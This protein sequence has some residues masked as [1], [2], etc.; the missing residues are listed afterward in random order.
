MTTKDIF[1]M[2]FIFLVIVLSFFFSWLDKNKKR[3]FVL[4]S[5]PILQ[6]MIDQAWSLINANLE[7]RPGFFD[8]L[9]E[10]QC[11]YSNIFY[12]LT[13]NSMNECWKTREKE[14]RALEAALICKINEIK[15]DIQILIDA[16]VQVPILFE[17]LTPVL[18]R[19]RDKVAFGLLHEGMARPHLD[20]AFGWFKD[21]CAEMRTKRKDYALMWGLL[22]SAAEEIELA[23]SYEA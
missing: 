4:N 1:W 14:V 7:V 19:L 23:Q 18:L 11:K 3:K 21:A 5:K 20:R 17:S 16:K 15:E 22:K 2:T 13:E 8:S 9:S 12:D 6:N 10:L